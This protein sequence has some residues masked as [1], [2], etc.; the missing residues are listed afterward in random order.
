MNADDAR[1]IGLNT[2]RID[3]HT[4]GPNISPGWVGLN[5][6][7]CGDTNGHLGVNLST[8]FCTCWRCHVRGPLFRILTDYFNI[9][10]GQVK[11]AFSFRE[12]VALGESIADKVASILTPDVAAQQETPEL[13]PPP[14]SRLILDETRVPALNDFLRRRRYTLD[15]CLDMGCYWGWVDKWKHRLI[16]PIHLHGR[17]IAWQGRIVF[18][19]VDPKYRSQGPINQTLY[20]IDDCLPGDPL[21]VVEGVLDQWRLGK[22]SVCSFGKKL[23]AT[24]RHL[25][26]RLRP[27]VVYMVWD[28]DAFWEI[29]NVRPELEAS[30]I[31]VYHIELPDGHDPDTL[32]YSG[33]HQLIEQVTA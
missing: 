11:A 24:Q 30:G 14:G 16:F 13:P 22:G 17:V 6:P 18:P 23:S 32:G 29:R 31:P 10:W 2:L 4:E 12:S 20:R 26:R 1:I 25:I 5:C 19:D 33:V 28:A 21:I 8:G 27:S 3:F 15:D 7:N 9:P